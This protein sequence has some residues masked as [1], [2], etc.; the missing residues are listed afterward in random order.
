MKTNPN[1]FTPF[2][3]NYL[4]ETEFSVLTMITNKYRSTLNVE[5]DLRVVI[6]NI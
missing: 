1:D 3:L 4:R 5:A 2:C 6:S